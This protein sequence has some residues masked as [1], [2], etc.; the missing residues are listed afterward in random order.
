MLVAVLCGATAAGKSA[1]ALRLAEANGFEILSADSRQIYRGLEI[2]TGAP[3]AA[4]KARVP[5]HLVGTVDPAY[6]FSPREYPSHAHRIL[7]ARPDARFLIVGGTG[8]YLKELLYPSPFDRGPTP[9]PIK[10]RVRER[11]RAEG[12]AA[13]HA[14]LLRLDPEGA[15]SIHPND[16]YRIAKR[17]ENLLLT[18]QSYARFTGP[19]VPD[20]RFQGVPVLWLDAERD[21]LYRRID[22]RVEAMVRGGWPEETR[23][24]MENPAW[25]TLPAFSSL[26]YAEMT[27][28]AEGKLG[29]EAAIAAIQKQT[30]NY[31]KRQR[32]FFRHQLPAAR[33][34]DA[35]AL[36]EAF[37]R[38]AWSW[39]AFLKSG[40]IPG[41]GRGSG[42]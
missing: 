38:R 1:L 35:D 39:D 12:P 4:E 16:A 27:D 17:W 25:R 11:L 30:R 18:G 3:T 23:R 13:L 26:G 34:F 37:A 6:G 36:R 32:T 15:A 22:A 14:E 28:V 19:P 5:H 41:N 8:L 2:G 10:L 20:P 21:P 7:D 29:L 40:Q 42:F 9:E 33:R 31:A 24:L